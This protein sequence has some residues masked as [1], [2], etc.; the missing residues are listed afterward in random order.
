M[1][2][3]ELIR[4]GST[5][6]RPCSLSCEVTY[7]GNFYLHLLPTSKRKPIKHSTKYGDLFACLEADIVLA[8]TTGEWR[9]C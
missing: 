2:A 5:C 3:D 4:K 6:S 7:A 1:H 9:R 8:M